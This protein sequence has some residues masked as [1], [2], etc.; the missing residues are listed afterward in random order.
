MVE[1]KIEPNPLASIYIYQRF[2]NAW[3]FF[4][5]ILNFFAIHN[6]RFFLPDFNLRGGLD[7]HQDFRQSFHQCFIYK[8]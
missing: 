5:K 7:F 6:G 4:P 3:D 2:L 1:V 8:L